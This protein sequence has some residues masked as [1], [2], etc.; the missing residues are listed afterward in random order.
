MSISSACGIFD[1]KKVCECTAMYT[2]GVYDLMEKPLY[3]FPSRTDCSS[4]SD[5]SDKKKTECK[6]YCV[7][8]INTYFGDNDA[9]FTT[10]G[11]NTICKILA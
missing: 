8:Q 2:M 4:L 6:E 5:C 10:T 11:M 9:S 3:Q 7:R 1:T